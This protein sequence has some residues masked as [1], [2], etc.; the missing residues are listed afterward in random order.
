MSSL[1]PLSVI[2]LLQFTNVTMN[3]ILQ[4]MVVVGAETG[5]VFDGKVEVSN[6]STLGIVIAI[7]TS[8]SSSPSSSQRRLLNAAVK[9]SARDTHQL[10]TQ[11]I[12]H[13]ASRISPFAGHGSSI[14]INTP[15]E[16]LFDG[17]SNTTTTPWVINMELYAV[18]RMN[19]SGNVWT[20]DTL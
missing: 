3:V 13:A 14:R 5:V 7:P 16:M 15:R 19:I 20:D 1:L 8:S 6:N 4:G 2:D 12:A 17:V 18:T 9:Q 10:L 11:S